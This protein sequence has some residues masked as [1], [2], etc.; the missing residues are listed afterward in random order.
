MPGK[1]LLADAEFDAAVMGEGEET[2]VDILAAWG[3]GQGDL[4]SVPGVMYRAPGGIMFTGMRDPI[5]DLDTI[6]SPYLSN[7]LGRSYS[8]AIMLETVR[9]CVYQCSYCAYHKL[10]RRLRGFDPGR[11]AAEVRWAVDSGV[12]E[13]IFIDPCFARGPGLRSLLDVLRDAQETRRFRASCELN[14]EDLD[15]GIV[16]ALA[17]AGVAHV[18]VGL[19]STNR[20]ALDLCRRRFHRDLFIRGVRMLKGAGMH[21]A[22]DIMVGLPGDTRKDV[23]IP[24]ISLW[25]TVFSAP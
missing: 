9:G 20:R 6:P 4:S 7:I 17:E 13:I 22:T 24:S 16:C 3:R 25:I 15:E 12:E 23:R 5:N 19:Q 21:V 8:G 10:F 2:L 18:E 14:A 1:P 11:T